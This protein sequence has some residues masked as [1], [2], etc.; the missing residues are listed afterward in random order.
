MR[1]NLTVNCHSGAEFEFSA[2][3]A[4]FSALP[5]KLD[6]LMATENLNPDVWSSLVVVVVAD[7]KPA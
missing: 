7:S 5:A 2:E 1:I 3:I 6:E 4:D